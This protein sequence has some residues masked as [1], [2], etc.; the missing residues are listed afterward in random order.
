M[1]R[2]AIKPKTASP[3]RQWI[4]N[5]AISLAVT[6]AIVAIAFGE[7]LDDYIGA[8]TQLTVRPQTPDLSHIL[9]ARPVIQVHLFAA[10]TALA[11]GIVLLIGVKGTT[12]HR[13]LGWAW[14]AAM[15]T[16]AVTSLFI[17]ELNQG[18]FSFIHLLTGW[19]IIVLPMAVFMA[20][21]HKVREHQRMM[22]GMFVGG[23]IIAGLFAFMP[24]RVLFSVFFTM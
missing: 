21:R 11:I 24:G 3:L 22:T 5:A 6:G 15:A 23:L 9:A 2:T 14:V 18:A 13:T 17:R 20:R 16:T 8:V 10:L 7:R 4:F 19:T 12:T 1:T